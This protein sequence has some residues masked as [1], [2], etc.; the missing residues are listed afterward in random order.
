[1][2]SDTVEIWIDPKYQEH[3]LYLLVPA[4][5][6]VFPLVWGEEQVHLPEGVKQIC[7]IK[8]DDLIVITP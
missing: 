1:M 3:S 6:Q 7:S 4:S 8:L 5:G 2:E